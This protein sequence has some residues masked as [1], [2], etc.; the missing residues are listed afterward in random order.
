M[1]CR[2]LHI[3]LSGLERE[4]A[5]S[6]CAPAGTAAGRAACRRLYLAAHRCRSLRRTRTRRPGS[7]GRPSPG[8]QGTR[9]PPA[10]RDVRCQTHRR[11]ELVQTAADIL[12]AERLRWQQAGYW[13]QGK[14]PSTQPW[15]HGPLWDAYTL[16]PWQGVATRSVHLLGLGVSVP[17]LQ[18]HHRDGRIA[19]P[20]QQLAADACASGAVYQ[21]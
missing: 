17:P 5:L 8:R 6:T 7:D 4:T 21:P 20:V 12:S 11:P 18:A 19:L 14:Q 13:A 16:S 1:A 15:L 3:R 2:H 10:V 9:S